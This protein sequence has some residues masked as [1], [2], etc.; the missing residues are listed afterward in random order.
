MEGRIVGKRPCKTKETL[1]DIGRLRWRSELG[2]P[3]EK[4]TEQR[5]FKK[6]HA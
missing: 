6:L 4:G 3:Q 1:H 2:L 5:S